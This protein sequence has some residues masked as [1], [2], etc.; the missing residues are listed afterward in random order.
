MQ[1]AGSEAVSLWVGAV[2]FGWDSYDWSSEQSRQEGPA[3]MA[4]AVEEVKQLAQDQGFRPQALGTGSNCLSR[5]SC[6]QC[7]CI[8]TTA[9]WSLVPAAGSAHQEQMPHQRM[10][11]LSKAIPL[12]EQESILTHKV[13]FLILSLSAFTCT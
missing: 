1:A 2:D 8:Y 7:S 4:Q 3:R 5:L 13:T 6:Q 9:Y 11:V 12:L 10:P